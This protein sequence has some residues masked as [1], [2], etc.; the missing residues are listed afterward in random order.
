MRA[1][2]SKLLRAI[3]TLTL[4][5]KF[6]RTFPTDDTLRQMQEDVWFVA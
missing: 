2:G 4:T 6:Q 1:L 3:L 5:L